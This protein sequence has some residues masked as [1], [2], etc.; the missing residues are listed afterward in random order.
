MDAYMTVMDEST[1]EDARERLIENIKIEFHDA[2]LELDFDKMD[3]IIFRFEEIGEMDAARRLQVV[4]N[5][6]WSNRKGSF[7]GL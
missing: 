6:A 2:R 1:A 5:A 7:W 3:D 4:R